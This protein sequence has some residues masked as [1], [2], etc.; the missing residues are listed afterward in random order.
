MRASLLF[1]LDNFRDEAA[2]QAKK[3]SSFNP[4]CRLR[5]KQVFCDR[6]GFAQHQKISGPSR[7]RAGLAPTCSTLG[8]QFDPKR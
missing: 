5:T 1:G 7:S 3:N 4:F 6:L 8:R 2:L